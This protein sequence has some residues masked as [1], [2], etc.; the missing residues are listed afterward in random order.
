MI[1]LIALEKALIAIVNMAVRPP[2]LRPFARIK[3]SKEL[4]LTH[5]GDGSVSGRITLWGWE[6]KRRHPRPKVKPKI[7]PKEIK[8][9]LNELLAPDYYVSE[10]EDCDTFAKL[11]IWHT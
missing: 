9:A 10:V 2:G 5:N 8:I 6:Y 7:E 1:D 3:Y 11:T 4:C